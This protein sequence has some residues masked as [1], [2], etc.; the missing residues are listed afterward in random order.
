MFDNHEKDNLT[1]VQLQ[2]IAD[3]MRENMNLQRQQID[4][5]GKT[6]EQ[7]SNTVKTFEE[8][9]TLNR[10]KKIQIDFSPLKKATE[11]IKELVG[12]L[13]GK[14]QNVKDAWEQG[15]K[16]R[17]DAK[18]VAAS[19]EA[20]DAQYRADITNSDIVIE[21][22][23][24]EIR[25]LQA[26]SIKASSKAMIE[27][28]KGVKQ[29]ER[30]YA[31]TV[32]KEGLK[33]FVQ[34]GKLIVP[35]RKT[36]GMKPEADAQILIDE[37]LK[38][39]ARAND[40]IKKLEQEIAE[41]TRN[42]FIRSAKFPMIDRPEEM[43]LDAFNQASKKI[44]ESLLRNASPEFAEYVSA[45]SH[46]NELDID[47]MTYDTDQLRQIKMGM[48]NGLD[49]SLYAN[50]EISAEKM[51]VIRTM[52]EW[53]IDAGKILKK[54]LSLEKGMTIE[55]LSKDRLLSV[56]VKALD[57]ELEKGAVGFRSFGE[58]NGRE[59]MESLNTVYK[60]I[61]RDLVISMDDKEM[62]QLKESIEKDIKEHKPKRNSHK[63]T[64]EG[65]DL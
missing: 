24:S 45:V 15:H 30:A 19:I 11:R 8:K 42:T 53:G 16:I 43:E 10:T 46:D 49:V 63:R 9:R 65:Q 21:N 52:Q 28:E 33:S 27:Y 60:D 2:M 57:E 26:V 40:A 54:E 18:K 47:V 14:Y 23:L 20:I 44:R 6:V 35:S 34:T 56:A 48:D 32:F 37:K 36:F 58:M 41:E 5:L 3:L 7:L 55:K 62:N 29:R 50:P 13:H 64:K 12:N 51:A 22:K 59:S 61:K 38:E 4:A 17:T 25:D 39:A 31:L 1:E